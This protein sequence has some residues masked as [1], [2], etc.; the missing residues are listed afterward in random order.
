MRKLG[1]ILLTIAKWI[2]KVILTILWLVLEG[3]KILLLLFGCVL[4][5]FL[6]LI[7]ITVP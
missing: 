6:S 4:K 2:L 5:L 3:L 1:S 7:R